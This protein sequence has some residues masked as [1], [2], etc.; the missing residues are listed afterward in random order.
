MRYAV[1]GGDVRF[2]HLVSMLNESERE[3]V[4][5]LQEHA[6]GEARP[7]KELANYSVLISNW[8]M[9]WPLSDADTSEEEI[10]GNIAPGSV[11]LLCGPGFPKEKRWDLQYVNLWA[12]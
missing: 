7:L 8:P 1:I 2:A 11:L 6:G 5:F 4:G 10:L 3:A 9:R 12:D